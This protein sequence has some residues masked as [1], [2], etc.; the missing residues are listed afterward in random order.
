MASLEETLNTLDYAHNARNIKNCPTINLRTSDSAAAVQEEIQRLKKDLFA[1]A[2]EQGI[3]INI[4]LQISKLQEIFMA[5]SSRHQ[6]MDLF[7]SV[8]HSF[9][10]LK[11]QKICKY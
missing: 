6:N 8:C 4:C 9:S 1:M 10:F 11:L 5:Y 7:F 3:S 2:N